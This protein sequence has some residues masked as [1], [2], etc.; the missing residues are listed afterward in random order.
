MLLAAKNLTKEYLIEKSIFTLHPIR[1]RAVN[2][3]NFELKR[4]SVLGVVGETGSGKSTLAKLIA[5]LISPTQGEIIYDFSDIRK[6]IQIIFQNPYSSLNPRLKIKTILTE[7]FLIHKLGSRKEIPRKIEDLLNK[8]NLSVS[9]LNKYP[10]EFSGG[11]RQR[12]AIARALAV[13]PKVLICDEP[14]SSL[15]LSIQAQILNLFINLKNE[16][17]LSYVFISHNLEVISFLADEVLILYKGI[18]VEKGSKEQIFN[19]PLHPYTKVLLAKNIV[20]GDEESEKG[21]T[22]GGCPFYFQCK[23]RFQDCLE[24][25]KEIEVEKAHYVKCHLYKR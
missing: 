12:I 25:P 4:E 15:D 11:Q 22:L 16:L 2:C 9:C 13:Q 14:T 8:T 20:A 6:S 7:P 21:R 23:H 3:V 17:K 5:K 24:M 1:V 18:D 10:D 19:N